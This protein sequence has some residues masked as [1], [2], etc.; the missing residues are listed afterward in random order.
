MPKPPYLTK[1]NKGY[2]LRRPV[3]KAFRNQ[4]GKTQWV[5]RLSGM[6]YSEMCERARCFGVETD[7]ELKKHRNAPHRSLEPTRRTIEPR[8]TLSLTELSQLKL[9]YFRQLEHAVEASGGYGA[10]LSSLSDAEHRDLQADAELDHLEALEIFTTAQDD[11]PEADT[12]NPRVGQLGRQ[13]IAKAARELLL[14]HNF[15]HLEQLNDSGQLPKA[16]LSSDGF[17]ALCSKLADAKVEHTRRRVDAFERGGVP[18]LQRPEMAQALNFAEP[19]N[20]RPE[21]TVGDL[22]DFYLDKKRDLVT[23]SRFNQYQLAVRA[24]TEEV[25]RETRLGNISRE[26]CEEIATLFVRTPQYATR[27]YEGMSIREAAEAYEKQHGAS[28]TR[29]DAAQDNLRELRVLL[30]EAVDREWLHKNPCARVRIVKPKSATPLAA[31]D[32]GYEPFTASELSTIFSAPLYTGCKDD[33]HGV[34]KVGPHIIRK[35][36]FWVPLVALYSGLRMQEVLQL[37]TSDIRQVGDVRY[38]SVN[39]IVSAEAAKVGHK[40]R[41]KTRNSVRDV[42]V[43]PELE[44]LGFLKHVSKAK[45]A[46]V[47]PELEG[48]AAEKLSDNFSKKFRSFLRPTGVWVSRRKVFHSFRGTFNDAL[49]DGEVPKDIREELLGWGDQHSMDRKYGKGAKLSKLQAHVQR[50]SYGS[51]DLSKL[52]VTD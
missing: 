1:D 25:G 38:M 45:G 5:E 46:L 20:T 29:F 18:D 12:D 36:R 39:D 26:H 16:V 6:P 23:T 7:A 35:A 51:L 21:K 32:D 11:L 43:H 2:K 42:P 33:G 40:K 17:E 48:G 31:L 22:I 47:F 13:A 28:A 37:E 19:L 52:F 14:E 44:K 4:I 3:P 8:F 10:G 34:N 49:R 24:L 50:V 41:L 27:H 15:I 9:A 30:D